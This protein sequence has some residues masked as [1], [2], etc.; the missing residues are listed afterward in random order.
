MLKYIAFTF[1]ILALF[2]CSCHNNQAGVAQSSDVQTEDTLRTITADMAYEGVNNYC[3]SAYDWSVAKDNPD[4]MYLTMGE[5]T[6]SA[7]QVVFRSYTGSLTHFYVDKLT[8][9]TRIVTKVPNLGV[10]EDNGTIDLHDY[11]GKEKSAKASSSDKEASTDNKS[12]TG[13]FVSDDDG[14]SLTISGR[15]DGRYSIVINLFRLTHLDDG[16]GGDAEGGIDFTATDANGEPIGGRITF[17]D[18]TATLTFIHS[19]WS[20]IE[21]GAKWEFRRK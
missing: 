16:V 5:E 10:E 7:Y 13:H 17:A 2:L 1:V 19:S 3:H 15:E 9:K 20:L 6:D 14:S 12:L 11:L 18:D 21:E 4:I 8:G